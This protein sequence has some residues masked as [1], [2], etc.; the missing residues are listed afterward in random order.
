MADHLFLYHKVGEVNTK[1]IFK[2]MSVEDLNLVK[3]K[4]LS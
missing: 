1:L 2:Y 3:L 4:N